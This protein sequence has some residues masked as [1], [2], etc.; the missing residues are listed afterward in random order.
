MAATALP[1][2]LTDSDILIDAE[3]GVRAAIDFLIAQ[4]VSGG[5]RL[6]VVSAM[7]LIAGC[8]NSQELATLNQFL[9]HAIVVEI[10]PSISQLARGWMESYFLSHG[11]MIADALI[12]ATAHDQRV[13]LFTK[14]VRHFQMLPGLTVI[15][16]Y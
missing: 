1:P 15:R 7:E 3:R 8:R 12:A 10:D 9:R 11:L 6:S 5:L 2:G 14:N 13:P 4:R 16:P